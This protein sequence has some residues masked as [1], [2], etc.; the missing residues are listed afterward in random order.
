MLFVQNDNADQ[1]QVAKDSTWKWLE[2]MSLYFPEAKKNQSNYI[3]KISLMQILLPNITLAR[4]HY[5]YFL[6]VSFLKVMKTASQKNQQINW[7]SNKT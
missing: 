4:P 1:I 6:P 2:N 3:T 7:N 5:K